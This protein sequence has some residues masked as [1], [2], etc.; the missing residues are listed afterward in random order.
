MQNATKITFKRQ[1]QLSSDIL[2]L[3]FEVSELNR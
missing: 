2:C 1:C 3:T